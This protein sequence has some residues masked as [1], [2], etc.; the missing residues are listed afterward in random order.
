[1]GCNRRWNSLERVS[2][3]LKVIEVTD[4]KRLQNRNVFVASRTAVHFVPL[5]LLILLSYFGYDL[6]A[7]FIVKLLNTSALFLAVFFFGQHTRVVFTPAANPFIHA[8]LLFLIFIGVVYFWFFDFFEIFA[9]S[10]IL[11][12]LAFWE[13]VARGCNRLGVSIIMHSKAYL[14]LAVAI[15]IVGGLPALPIAISLVAVLFLAAV[16]LWLSASGLTWKAPGLTVGNNSSIWITSIA[17][18]INSNLDVLVASYFL[19]PAQTVQYFLISR[20]VRAP[21]PYVISLVAHMNTELSSCT[22]DDCM[23]RVFREHQARVFRLLSIYVLLVA[24]A[25]VGACYFFPLDFD[26]VAIIC[27]SFCLLQLVSGHG[28]LLVRLGK[29]YHNLVVS[30]L[31]AAA[32]LGF[33]TALVLNGFEGSADLLATTI[34]LS[35][36]IKLLAVRF[37]L[38]RIAT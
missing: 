34:G 11:A 4:M 35:A 30:C 23:M 7:S 2:A 26:L 6:E 22:N 19:P 32:G 8:V 27:I 13:H 5:G 31:G 24:V 16:I 18:L 1:M 3:G 36:L 29:Y 37:I 25:S 38:A 20:I 14:L 21:E 12:S 33:V 9:I 17:N 10:F 28:F 15:Y